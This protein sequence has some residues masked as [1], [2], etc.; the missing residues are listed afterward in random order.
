MNS[1]S[2]AEAGDQ[3]SNRCMSLL[4]TFFVS[5]FILPLC[6]GSAEAMDI[7]VVDHQLIASGAIDP[8]DVA[9]LPIALRAPAID[10]IVLLDSVGG[11]SAAGLQMGRMIAARKLKTVIVGSCAGACPLVFLGGTDRRFAEGKHVKSTFILLDGMRGSKLTS[12]DAKAIRL[13]VHKQLGGKYVSEWTDGPTSGLAGETATLHIPE[14]GRARKGSQ[15]PRYCPALISKES[16][17]KEITGQDAFTMGW[18]S[19]PNTLPIRLPSEFLPIPTFFGYVLNQPEADPAATLLN[20]GISMCAEDVGCAD[21]FRIAVPRFQLQKSFRATALGF[22]RKGFGFSDNQSSPEAAAKR[23]LFLC[24]HTPG[25]QKLCSIAMID[26]FDV[27]SLYLQ[28]VQSSTKALAGL[29]LPRQFFWNGEEKGDT[30]SL[31]AQLQ[32]GNTVRATPLA[33][34]GLKTWNTGEVAQALMASHITLVDVHG[35]GAQ[36][37]PGATFMWDA[38]LALDDEVLDQQLEERLTAL[39]QVVVPDKTYPIVFYCA[40]SSCWA[41]INAA[42]RALHGG[43]TSVGWYRGGLKSWESAGL[44]LVQKLPLAAIF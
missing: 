6:C 9:R 30:P 42:I 27:S 31:P 7:Q 44:P 21:R 23:A 2:A 25:N 3:T 10:E 16:D 18:I 35:L 39:L 29:D 41:A 36:M 32:K 17:C 43:Y 22:G 8:V 1:P 5:T 26:G 24:N 34:A 38:G 12:E 37:I 11:D 40:D 4:C 33:V 15:V 19:D 13:Y 28:I 20:R 14:P